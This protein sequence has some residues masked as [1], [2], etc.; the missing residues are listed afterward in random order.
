ML[1]RAYGSRLHTVELNFD[2]K[3]LNEIGF[4]RDHGTSFDRES[5]LADHERVSLHE[6]TAE[7][8]GYVHDEVETQALARLEEHVRSALAELGEAELIVVESEGAD[9]PKT[10]QT[11]R[12]VV[13]EG[14]NRLHFKVHVDPPLRLG[15][16]RA[17]A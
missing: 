16:Y 7:A 5:F 2:S 4:R 6:F 17:K 15:V 13:L 8:E 10:R 9:Y 12:N 11:T 3:A 14:E 1:L